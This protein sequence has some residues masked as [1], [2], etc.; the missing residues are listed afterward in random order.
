MVNYLNIGDIF[1]SFPQQFT[2]IELEE[3]YT[4]NINDGISACMS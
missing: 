1:T 4:G 3:C 2:I